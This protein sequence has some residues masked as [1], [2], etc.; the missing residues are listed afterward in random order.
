VLRKEESE[1]HQ[2]S[3]RV[4]PHPWRGRDRYSRER[5][6]NKRFLEVGR[7]GGGTND[8]LNDGEGGDVLCEL[9][10]E[11]RHDEAVS[12]RRRDDQR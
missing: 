1:T 7:K 5:K 3:H 10:I 8:A 12:E 6:I 2:G 11:T 4:Q 9:H